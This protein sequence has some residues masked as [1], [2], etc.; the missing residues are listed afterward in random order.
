MNFNAVAHTRILPSMFTSSGANSSVLAQRRS[1]RSRIGH[2]AM[3]IARLVLGL[4]M[5]PYAIDKL[6][7]YQFKVE[8]SIYAQPLGWIDGK[9]LTW[10]TLG[11]SPR[12]QVLL[13]VFE[14]LPALLL[15]NART[16]RLGALFLFPVLLNV[17]LINFL[18]DLWPGTKIVSS[19]LLALNIFLLLYDLPFYLDIFNRLLLPPDSAASPKLRLTTFFIC[20]TSIIAFI[21]LLGYSIVHFQIPLSD[22]IG[23]RPI[24]GAGAWKIESLSIAGQPVLVAPSNSFFFNPFNTCVYGDVTNV[25]SPPSICTFDV[26]KTRHSFKIEK[27]LL[28]GSAGTIAG[29]YQVQGDRL[30]LNGSRNNQPI[31]LI[32]QR[33]HWNHR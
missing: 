32:L 31:A 13:G 5:M 2:V 11:F 23:N 28:E 16:R 7:I 33:I 27:L 29:T 3:T 25:N 26:D 18:F 10:A 21:L 14:F 4:G 8:A 19:F 20:A 17:V 30:L 9:T 24:N 22:F 6:L 1:K 12:Y 15:L